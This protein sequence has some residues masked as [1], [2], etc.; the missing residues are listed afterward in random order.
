[1]ASDIKLKNL[2]GT[3]KEYRGVKSVFL[4]R[5]DGEGTEEYIQPEMQV[6]EVTPRAEAQEIEPE[7][8][9]DGLSKVVVAKIP[10]SETSNE[11][12]GKTVTIG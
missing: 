12:G 8:N 9:F 3:E 10:Y 5:A 1:M 4:P 7:D 6:R 11:A 2:V